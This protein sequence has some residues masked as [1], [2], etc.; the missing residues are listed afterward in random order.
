M[1]EATLARINADQLEAATQH[2]RSSLVIF[3]G[4]GSGKTFTFTLRIAHLLAS[5]VPPYQILALT[6]TKKAA[7]TRPTARTSGI[8]RNFTAEI[9]AFPMPG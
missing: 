1:K 3:A 7:N 6:V 2:L 8:S 9:I 4:P 5:G